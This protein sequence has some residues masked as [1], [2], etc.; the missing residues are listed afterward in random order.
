MRKTKQESSYWVNRAN[1][2]FKEYPETKKVEKRYTTLK[3]L[4]QQKYKSITDDAN[5]KNF[6]KDAIYLDR[7]IRWLTEGEQ[8]DLKQTLADKFIEEE[9]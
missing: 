5:I 7:K 9:L 6:L 3:V 8:I 1:R 2:L 4:L